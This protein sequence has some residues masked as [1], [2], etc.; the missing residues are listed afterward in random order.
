[1]A[2]KRGKNK[3]LIGF[4]VVFVIILGG[5]GAAA[6]YGYSFFDKINTVDIDSD[7][8]G[9]DPETDKKL[10][11]YSNIENIALFGVDVEQGDVGRSDSI[12]ILTLD[13]NNNKVKLTSIM[14]D[15]YVNIIGRSKDKLNHAYAYGGAQLAMQTLNNNFDL[16]IKDF[17]SVNFSGLQK[18]IDILGG[19]E[20]TIT[21]DEI[22][23]LADY[24]NSINSFTN[25]KAET[26]KTPGTYNLNGT[27]ALAYTRIRYTEGND[28]KRTERQRTVLTQVFEKIKQTSVTEWP[29]LL[30]EILPLVETSM[31]TSKILGLGNSIIKMGNIQVE[32]ERFPLDEECEGT[33]IG[34]VYYLQ[35]D[36][37]ATVASLHDYI[38]E[39]T[40]TWK[41]K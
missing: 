35:F 3:I 18:I 36:E 29:S 19:V 27:Q 14:R 4:L 32:Q 25:E 1:M 34:G 33:T 20:V 28:Y 16:N 39:D 31:D 8:L 12:M 37:E 30:N 17:A 6:I 9:I 41:E 22:P 15:S 7:D 24:V 10:S 13:K 23:Y 26:I 11:S 2:K 5:I 38:F 40:K 21:Q